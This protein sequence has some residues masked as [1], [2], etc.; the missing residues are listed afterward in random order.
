MFVEALGVE[1]CDLVVLPAM[2]DD[3]F[4]AFVTKFGEIRGPCAYI[5]G[6]EG[7]SYGGVVGGECGGV[8]GGVVDDVLKPLLGE[9]K[10]CQ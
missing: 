5:G 8:P 4:T 6:V 7:F 3:H 1:A 10:G 9:T 2:I